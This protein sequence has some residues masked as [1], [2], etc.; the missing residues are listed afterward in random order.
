MELSF[1]DVEDVIDVNERFICSISS[2]RLW[3]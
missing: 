2:K 1:V 3:A